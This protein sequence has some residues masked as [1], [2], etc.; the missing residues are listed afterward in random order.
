MPN[1]PVD[2]QDTTEL[3]RIVEINHSLSLSCAKK[4]KEN[5]KLQKRDLLVHFA[6]LVSFTGF[7][8]HLFLLFCP[9]ITNRTF[10]AGFACS[11]PKFH[12]DPDFINFCLI[13]SPL[14]LTFNHLTLTSLLNSPK[15]VTQSISTI[16]LKIAMTS[17][18]LLN[19][20][21]SSLNR[22]EDCNTKPHSGANIK[23]CVDLYI[24][25]KATTNTRY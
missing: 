5:E 16:Y 7:Y 15:Q 13:F 20:R 17:R 12:F 2:L 24:R 10:L 22:I 11:K 1:T 19:V 21:Y 9:E 3:D 18:E 23:P 8:V 25:A 14:L 4:T 6:F